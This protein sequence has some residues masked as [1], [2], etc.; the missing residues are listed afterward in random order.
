MTLK[1]NGASLS[2]VLKIYLY[3]IHGIVSKP[4]VLRSLDSDFY[5]VLQQTEDVYHSLL[6]TLIGMP[7]TPSEFVVSVSTYPL[8]N[9]IWLGVILMCV[10]IL[11]PLFYSIRKPPRVREAP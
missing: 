8:M 5:I 1:R 7:D 3:T 2:G 6:H 4:L 9:L 11:F 10:G